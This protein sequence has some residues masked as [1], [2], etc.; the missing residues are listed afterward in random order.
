MEAL[1]KLC[2][3]PG[4]LIALTLRAQLV[5]VRAA[6]AEVLE[7]LPEDPGAAAGREAL[8][9]LD[10]VLERQEPEGAAAVD[11]YAPTRARE[12][13]ALAGLAA[14]LVASPEAS[15]YLGPLTVPAETEAVFLW[16]W[17]HLTLLRLPAAQAH[18]WRER[19][20]R[21]APGPEA[22]AAG[23]WVQWRALNRAWDLVPPLPDSGAPGLRIA[24][25]EQA[26]ADPSPAADLSPAAVYEVLAD[27]VT[28]LAA[29]DTELHHCL[30]VLTHRGLLP[31]HEAGHRKAYEQELRHRIARLA[32]Q[33]QDSP[34]ALRA[35]LAVDE[36][37]CSVLH[38]P[39]AAPGSWW[40]EVAG[41]SQHT[42]LELRRR[43]RGRGAD[44]AV[45]V[46]APHYRDARQRTGGND[47]PLDA[48]GL[49]GQVLAV[50]RLW[51]RVEGQEMRGRVVYRG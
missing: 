17:F 48:G 23:Q 28:G 27:W 11:A 40:A 49:K 20:A 41:T 9:E 10:A 39:P 5:G 34:E 42:V 50:L 37:L 46:P 47:I 7:A 35:A 33:P 1:K 31:L 2:T 30:E 38:L 6:L 8:R 21:L 18:R 26:T 22:Q 36:A 15:N 32:R 24:A 16:R 14:E 43:V 19:A 44:V 4:S 12:T 51:A 29:Y 25:D 3:E 13:H 45:E